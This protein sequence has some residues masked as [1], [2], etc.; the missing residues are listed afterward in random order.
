MEIQEFPDK[1]FKITLL[2][3]LRDLQENTD[4]PKLPQSV[5]N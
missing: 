4:K 5:G 1:I 2:K 3:M